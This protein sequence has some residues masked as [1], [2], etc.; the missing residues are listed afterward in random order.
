MMYTGS[1]AQQR[2]LDA[3]A[4]WCG[5]RLMALVEVTITMAT[6]TSSWYRLDALARIFHAVVELKHLV[7]SEYA[8]I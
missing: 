6:K 1:V 2:V 7:E 5:E 3:F 8:R 4:Q